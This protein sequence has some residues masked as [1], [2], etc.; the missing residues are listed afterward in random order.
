MKQHVAALK[1]EAQFQ[2]K[3]PSENQDLRDRVARLENLS[4]LIL[5]SLNN[6]TVTASCSGTTTIITLTLP[7]LP[8]AC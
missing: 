5:Y 7:D 6:M 1:L 2:Q 8:G 3:P 4:C